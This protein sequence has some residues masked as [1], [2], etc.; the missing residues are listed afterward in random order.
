MTQV[1]EIGFGEGGWL[2]KSADSVLDM[3]IIIFFFSRER[4]ISDVSNTITRS[5]A[6]Q[7]NDYLCQGFSPPGNA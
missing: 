6:N 2:Y 7:Q 4:E 1:H 5:V 3:G